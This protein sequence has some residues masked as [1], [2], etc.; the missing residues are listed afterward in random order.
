MASEQI[1]LIPQ[2]SLI[3]IGSKPDFPFNCKPPSG[4]LSLVSSALFYSILSSELALPEMITNIWPVQF[5]LWTHPH[6]NSELGE[7]ETSWLLLVKIH[8]W[9][10]F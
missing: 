10:S 8:N 5:I 1:P 3:P 2:A 7:S 6:K 4:S 9:A